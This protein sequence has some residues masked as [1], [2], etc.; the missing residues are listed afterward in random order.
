MNFQV[1]EVLK[2]EHRELH[3]KLAEALAHPGEIGAAAQIVAERLHPH[4][5]KEE[6]FALPPLGLL[7]RL[8]RGEVAAD[9]AEVRDLTDRLEAEL[10]DM[11]REHEEISAALA[12]LA[13]IAR[14]NGKPEI[15]ETADS[16]LVHARTEE[17]LTYPTVLLVGRYVALK[18]GR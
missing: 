8:S 18:L 4:F 12:N 17:A 13:E 2:E 5:E 11:L 16:I 3:A 7:A 15:A 9:M 6:A 1:P 10:P 14:R